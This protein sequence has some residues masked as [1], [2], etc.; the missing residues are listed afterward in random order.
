MRTAVNI[1]DLALD[2][3]KE[4]GVKRGHLITLPGAGKPADTIDVMV[5]RLARPVPGQPATEK[6][7]RTNQ[8]IRL[9]YGSGRSNGRLRLLGGE[10]APGQ[11][12]LAQLRLEEPLLT[13]AND[14]IVIRDWSG[15]GTLAGARVLEPQGSRRRLGKED[16]QK[17]LS[18]LAEDDSP[19]AHL[20]YLF[21]ELRYLGGKPSPQK[22]PFSNR[23][24]KNALKA[25]SSRKEIEK[26]SQG[27]A[28]RD[29]WQEIL[30]HAQDQVES[31]HRKNPDL[32][33]LSLQELRN[34]LQ[35]EL[36]APEVLDLLLRALQDKGIRTE[37]EHLKSQA[38]QTDI[39]EELRQEA[40]DILA[41][42]AREKLNAP[43]RKDLSQTAGRER[44]L[45]FLIRVKQVQ[46]LDEKTVLHPDVIAEASQRITTHLSENGSATASD[47]RQLLDTSRRVAM[48]LLEHL[49]AIGLT[50]REGDLRH[51][52]SSALS[53]F[54]YFL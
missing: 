4:K 15:D 35:R 11:S 3:R 50:R 23:A 10:L 13:F 30:T 19:E 51:L 29:W 2:S 5:T 54:N 18:A 45:A 17:N 22:F 21:A 53:S 9:H 24:F 41:I 52:V 1:P 43:T 12:G 40:D 7:L 38:H 42:L 25:L 39:P 32:P 20:R 46:S 27:H 26:L 6:P 31:F 28:S 34:D 8:K 37:G 36:P 49:D 16:H 14:R 33:G 44:A 47:L 48:P